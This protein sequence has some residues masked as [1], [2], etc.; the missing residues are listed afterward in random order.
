MEKRKFT[1]HPNKSEYV[2]LDNTFWRR[3]KAI[4]RIFSIEYRTKEELRR[5]INKAYGQVYDAENYFSDLEEK[6][7]DASFETGRLRNDLGTLQ[8]YEQPFQEDR[9]TLDDYMNNPFNKTNYDLSAEERIKSLYKSQTTIIAALSLTKEQQKELLE[10]EK[11]LQSLEQSALKS[12]TALSEVITYLEENDVEILAVSLEKEE[13]RY[14]YEII[15]EKD[16]LFAR[17]MYT[18]FKRKGENVEFNSFTTYCK[19]EQ[20]TDDLTLPINIKKN[21]TDSEIRVQEGA[22]YGSTLKI[23]KDARNTI[24]PCF[25]RSEE[26]LDTTFSRKYNFVDLTDTYMQPTYRL[27]NKKTKR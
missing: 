5:Q 2:K 4:P 1:E 26:E 14:V 21:G 12:L 22:I 20:H 16:P 9:L 18:D 3:L 27:Q 24:L 25:I 19:V 7:R 6:L 23:F 17:K 15:S 10:K 13:E 8:K 11:K